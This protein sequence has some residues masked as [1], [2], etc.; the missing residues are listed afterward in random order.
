MKTIQ[1]LVGTTS[2]NT[3]FLADYTADL[4]QQQN[5]L[6]QLHYQPDLTQISQ[7]QPWLALLA[8]HGAGDYAE[9]MTKFYHQLEQ[10]D[11]L[12]PL[13]YSVIAIGESCYD[14]YC[15]AGHHL[16][17]RLRDLGAIRLSP[18]LEIDMLKDDPETSVS[19]WLPN[20]IQLLGSYPQDGS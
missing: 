11:Q 6:S 18:P 16:D 3:E 2:G 19:Q 8:S 20:W 5:I 15:A 7:D 13:P 12:T 9:S 14:T 4:L 10:L 17:K 1:I